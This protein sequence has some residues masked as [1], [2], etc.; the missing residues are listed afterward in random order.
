MSPRSD[1]RA[2]APASTSSI[3]VPGRRPGLRDVRRRR[4]ARLRRA[5]TRA[6]RGRTCAL[7][8]PA[9]GAGTDRHRQRS[10]R[11]RQVARRA[12]RDGRRHARRGGR[13]RA[14]RRRDRSR[15]RRSAVEHPAD[16]TGAGD[17]LAA[18]YIWA[19]LHGAEPADR[20]RWA[21]LYAS[22]A[23]TSADRHRRRRHRGG[24]A[25]GRSR[26]RA[27]RRRPLVCALSSASPVCGSKKCRCRW[28][29][30]SSIVLSDRDLVA[31]VDGGA[32]ARALV[33][34]EQRRLVVAR[35]PRSRRGWRRSRLAARRSGRGGS[36]RRRAPRSRRAAP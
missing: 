15:F 32:E 12:R 4:R 29:T 5:H 30:A 3:V 7:R 24:A 14:Q 18:A 36:R 26:A 19:D 25:R 23:V 13:D 6:A 31:A 11:A 27:R 34:R 33:V 10:R 28:S 16:S 20:L 22:L 8:Q 1:P 21:V 2:V 17:L 35:P 9:R